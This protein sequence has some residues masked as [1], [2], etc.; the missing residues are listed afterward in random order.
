MYIYIIYAHILMTMYIR[1]EINTENVSFENG[2]E[3]CGSPVSDVS[4]DTLVD[5][6]CFEKVPTEDLENS[7]DKRDVDISDDLG[8]RDERSPSPESDHSDDTL[9]NSECGEDMSKGC[10]GDWDDSDVVN[11]DP[12]D[13]PMES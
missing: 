7:D 8:D 10:L 1:L 2:E 11:G 12:E 9:A 3:R 4:D 13:T 6:E 5:S